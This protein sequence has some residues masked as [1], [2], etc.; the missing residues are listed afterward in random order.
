MVR[1]RQSR[2]RAAVRRD[3]QRDD[4]TFGGFIVSAY[5]ADGGPVANGFVRLVVNSHLVEFR[6]TQ[7]YVIEEPDRTGSQAPTR[8]CP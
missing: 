3:L 8:Q 6:G 2:Y 5:T 7:R 4:L 1:V